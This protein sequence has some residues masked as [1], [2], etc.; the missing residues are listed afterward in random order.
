MYQDHLNQWNDALT[1]SQGVF[2]EP[3]V[4]NSDFAKS[5]KKLEVPLFF[6]SGRHDYDTPHELVAKYYRHVAAPKKDLVWFERS[7]HFPFL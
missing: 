2:D 3:E 7:A 1:F 5:V 6:L 4:W